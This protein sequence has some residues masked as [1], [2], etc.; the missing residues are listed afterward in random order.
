MKIKSI[1]A[2]KLFG[3]HSYD[4]NLNKDI[5]FVYGSNALGKTTLAEIVSGKP[6]LLADKIIINYDEPVNGQKKLF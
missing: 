2:R 1:K 5:S 4:I 6:N 3:Y